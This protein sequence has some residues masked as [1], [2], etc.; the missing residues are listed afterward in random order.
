[1]HDLDKVDVLKP[2][3]EFTLRICENVKRMLEDYQGALGDLDKVDVLQPN[4][5]L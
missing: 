4:N 5:A 1:L 2:Y 3:S